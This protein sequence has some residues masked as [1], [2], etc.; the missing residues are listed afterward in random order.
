MVPFVLFS[1]YPIRHRLTKELNEAQKKMKDGSVE[2]DKKTFLK[3]QIP[4]MESE[5][6]NYKTKVADLLESDELDPRGEFFILA[7]KLTK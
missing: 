3:A 2:A 5:I 7:Q 4:K 1:V 6:K